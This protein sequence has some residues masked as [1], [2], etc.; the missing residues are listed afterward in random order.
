MK[1]KVCRS[2]LVGVFPHSIDRNNRTLYFT[3]R[4]GREIWKL[5]SSGKAVVDGTLLIQGI[6]K[7]MAMFI[8]M[9]TIFK[10]IPIKWITFGYSEIISLGLKICMVVAIGTLMMS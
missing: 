9:L 7:Q 2:A 5:D 3:S 8:L 4:F 10:V 1:H 6:V